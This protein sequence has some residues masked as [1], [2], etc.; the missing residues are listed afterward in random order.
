MSDTKTASGHSGGAIAAAVIGGI[1]AVIAA[2]ITVAGSQQKQPV[3]QPFQPVAS[4][5]GRPAK[6]DSEPPA[7][8]A[9]PENPDRLA[10]KEF[11]W[12]FQN[13]MNTWAS[14][15]DMAAI[16]NLS[17]DKHNAVSWQQQQQM[18]EMRRLWPLLMA[19]RGASMSVTITSW[20]PESIDGD[21]ASVLY[22]VNFR[23]QEMGRIEENQQ[24]GRMKLAKIRGEW[25]MASGGTPF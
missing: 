1:F 6:G 24:K 19:Q 12:K 15:G 16:L 11:K 3:P 25:L 8:E 9:P 20:E 21:E 23:G 10:L 18:E 5:D 22:Q 7:S 13:A 2:L 17:V 14:T 4:N